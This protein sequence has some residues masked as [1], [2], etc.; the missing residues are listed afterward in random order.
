MYDRPPEEGGTPGQPF[1]TETMDYTIKLN[2]RF[3]GQRT[4][5][6]MTQLGTKYQPYRFGSGVSAQQYVVEATAL[7]DSR[8][9]IG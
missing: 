1:S 3:S 2:H 8:S 7:Q 9:H 6:F 5:T 4:L